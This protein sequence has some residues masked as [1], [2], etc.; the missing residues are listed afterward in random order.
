MV[1]AEKS[2]CQ[3]KAIHVENDHALV[4]K[5]RC[6]G[7]GLCV[8][9]YSTQSFSMVHKRPKEVPLLFMDGNALMQAMSKEK[10][11]PFPFD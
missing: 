5:D 6:I 8:S 9:S 3:V 11:K 2:R 1:K 10:N 4:S 7:C